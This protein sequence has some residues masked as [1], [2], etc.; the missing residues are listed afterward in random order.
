[1]EIVWNKVKSGIDRVP[2]CVWCRSL[3]GASVT[4]LRW[5][6]VYD[7]KLAADSA[8]LPLDSSSLLGTGC[9]CYDKVF[10][11]CHLSYPLE[12]HVNTW[13]YTGIIIINSKEMHH[14][15]PLLMNCLCI[16]LL[17]LVAL[18]VTVNCL[19]VIW[20]IITFHE[21]ISGQER[22]Q[23]SVS[24]Y[25]CLLPPAARC[26]W[27]QSWL[28]VMSWPPLSEENRRKQ[29]SPESPPSLLPENEDGLR[30]RLDIE[31]VGSLTN[32]WCH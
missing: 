16:C 10:W 5:G 29:F 27:H 18:S 6:G 13:L 30:T 14:C 24:G 28:S 3:V 20:H 22:G 17:I 8:I 15:S 7:L 4:H 9:L 31:T 21:L 1:M 25:P 19:L 26:C 12:A 32:Y 11:K 2:S 23:N